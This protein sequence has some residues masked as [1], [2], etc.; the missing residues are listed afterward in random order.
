VGISNTGYSGESIRGF[1]TQANQTRPTDRRGYR[2]YV[3]NVCNVCTL[4]LQTILWYV[5]SNTYYFVLG[6][7]SRFRLIRVCRHGVS[8]RGLLFRKQLKRAEREGPKGLKETT[9]R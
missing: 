4:S 8:E 9:F 2:M 5:L 6:K 7:E 1:K 3:C